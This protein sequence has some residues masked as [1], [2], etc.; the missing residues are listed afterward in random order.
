MPRA[1]HR[2]FRG[3]QAERA[4]E[5]IQPGSEGPCQIGSIGNRDIRTAGKSRK[6][7]PEGKSRREKRRLAH[8]PC[9]CQ[10][11]AVSHAVRNVAPCCSRRPIR[12]PVVRNA[13]SNCIPASSA[14]ISIPPAASS[15]CNPFLNAFLARTSATSARFTPCVSWSRRRLLRPAPYRRAM[16]ARLLRTCLRSSPRTFWLTQTNP[17]CSH[18]TPMLSSVMIRVCCVRARI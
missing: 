17:Q 16:R 13:A 14:R 10:R 8:G 5:T 6:R 4:S 9:K 2:A 18:S 12:L 1:F 15:A 3:L 11:R 7:N